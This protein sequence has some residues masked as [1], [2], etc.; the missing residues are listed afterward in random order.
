MKDIHASARAANFSPCYVSYRGLASDGTNQG[1]T[2][3]DSLRTC[4]CE[5]S[6][7]LAKY[8]ALYSEATRI[9]LI[10]HSKGGLGACRYLWD[11]LTSGGL[12][13]NVKA[14]CLLACPVAVQEA[15]FE[16]SPAATPEFRDPFVADQH[17]CY[18][19][20]DHSV[21]SIPTHLIR[22]KHD[23]LLPVAGD[24]LFKPAGW[25]VTDDQKSV[26]HLIIVRKEGPQ[27]VETWLRGVA[28]L[29][30]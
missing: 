20:V 4:V 10:G 3:R 8:V 5:L 12:P 27:A 11:Q 9:V 26:G 23:D 6:S 18:Y 24:A 1:Y 17:D 29:A 15:V 28:A 16:W 2:A 30:P 25:S 7:T 19:P 22:P 14:L 21:W 13:S